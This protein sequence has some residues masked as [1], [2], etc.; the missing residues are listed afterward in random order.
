MREENRDTDFYSSIKDFNKIVHEPIRL[1]ILTILFTLKNVDYSSF[2]KELKIQDGNLSTHLR[3][4]EE[5]NYIQVKKEFVKRRPRTIYKITEK[6][7]EGFKNHIKK[8]EDL[9]SKI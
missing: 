3:K 2:K 9:L 7:K 5:E 1:G 8:L 4:L 6:G